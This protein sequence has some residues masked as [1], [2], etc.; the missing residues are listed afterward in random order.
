MTGRKQTPEAIEKRV[1]KM[2]GRKY[3]AEHCKNISDGLRGKKRTPEQI[4]RLSEAHMGSKYPPKT[5]EFRKRIS[6]ARKAYWVRWHEEKRRL[7][8]ITL[9]SG[10]IAAFEHQKVAQM[11]NIRRA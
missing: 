8:D 9:G 6:E 7:S 5:D 2:R 3:S 1:S 10:Q 4:K 11:E